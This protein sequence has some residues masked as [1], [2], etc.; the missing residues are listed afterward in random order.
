M[1]EFAGNK[2]VAFADVNLSEV[3]GERGE[4]RRSEEFQLLFR[5]QELLEQVEDADTHALQMSGFA[6]MQVRR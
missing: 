5:A 1:Q 4:V 2:K 6:R 3:R